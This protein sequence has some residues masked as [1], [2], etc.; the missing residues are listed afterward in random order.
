VHKH[1]TTSVQCL[2]NEF[3]G[4][5]KMLQQVFVFDVVNLYHEVF[6]RAKQGLVQ[7]QTQGRN[8]MCNSSLFQ[9]FFATQGEKPEE[10][11]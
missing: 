10:K 9:R 8:D 4:L 1:T 2:L 11:P 6:E 3:V 5:G 7:G